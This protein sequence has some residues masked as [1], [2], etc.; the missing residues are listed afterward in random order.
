MEE[1]TIY[2]GIDMHSTHSVLAF[3]DEQGQLID[4]I[5]VQTRSEPLKRAVSQ[6]RGEHKQLVIEQGTQSTWAANLLSEQVD[7]VYICDPGEN[8]S[9]SRATYKNDVPDARE[10]ADLLRCGRITQ[11][12]WP[13]INQR[14]VFRKRYDY[15]LKTV[16]RQTQARQYLI[17]QLRYWGVAIPRGD[18]YTRSKLSDWLKQLPRPNVRRDM[19]RVADWVKQAR[20]DQHRSWQAVE[21]IAS[22]Y[23]EIDWLQ[24][25]PGIAEKGSHGL[26]AYL[27]NPYRFPTVSKLY[28]YSGLGICQHRSDGAQV[29]G[30]H[31][32]HGVSPLKA[33][34][35][36]AYVV[37]VHHTKAD[38]V[39]KH[40]YQQSCQRS[41][42]ERN[43]RLN[44][45]RK[46]LKTCWSLWKHEAEFNPARFKGQGA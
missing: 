14:L 30:D 2:I 23:P 16:A 8:P 38:N 45:Q 28:A 42:S 31:L 44:T 37:A 7:Q 43:A 18:G 46:I 26:S 35:Y 41:A 33:I 13:L 32:L 17:S 15:Y 25:V 6:V 1:N 36:R 20:Q 19:Q 39:I 5:K 29:R 11:Q 4:D 21:Q 34:T 24:T 22:D 27:M 40:F 12:A 3:L 9:I 10:L